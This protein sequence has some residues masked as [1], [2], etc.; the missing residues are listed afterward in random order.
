MLR[1][2]RNRLSQNMTNGSVLEGVAVQ[3]SPYSSYYIKVFY[4]PT[5]A[6]YS[7]FQRI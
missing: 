1:G 6:Q 4:L 2:N 7:C 5:Y 3:I